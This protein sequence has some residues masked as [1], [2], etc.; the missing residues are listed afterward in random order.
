MTQ[1]LRSDFNVFVLQKD[2]SA[3]DQD[4]LSKKCDSVFH[5]RVDTV[6]SPAGSSSPQEANLRKYSK[7]LFN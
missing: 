6:E 1:F 3:I 2:L 4:G 7:K 5:W